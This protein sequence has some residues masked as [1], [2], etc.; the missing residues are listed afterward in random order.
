LRVVPA[1]VPSRLRDDK[2]RRSV[3]R[4]AF[5]H[6]ARPRFALSASRFLAQARE[7]TRTSRAPP[8]ARRQPRR[9]PSVALRVCA[10]LSRS[11]DPLARARDTRA[12][13]VRARPLDRQPGGGCREQRRRGVVPQSRASCQGAASQRSVGGLPGAVAPRLGD[14]GH[15]SALRGR[16]APA[17]VSPEPP[18]SRLTGAKKLAKPPSRVDAPSF[19]LLPPRC[20]TAAPRRI[21]LLL[22]VSL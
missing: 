3:A 4:S 1:Q 8:A 7:R 6:A 21:P 11:R 16:F 15:P 19:I 17:V 18:L 5:C 2:P 13:R 20:A 14:A 10:T 22:L 9:Q 12:P